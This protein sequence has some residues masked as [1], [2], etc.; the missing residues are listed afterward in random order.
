MYTIINEYIGVTAYESK[1][2]ENTDIGTEGLPSKYQI[3]FTPAE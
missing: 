3:S 2:P 1:L